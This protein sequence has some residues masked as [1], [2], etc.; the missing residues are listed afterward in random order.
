MSHLSSSEYC[1]LRR[2]LAGWAARFTPNH[3]LQAHLIE[4]TIAETLRTYPEKGEDAAIDVE[5]FDTMRRLALKEFK[6]GK[7]VHPHS[8]STRHSPVKPFMEESF[9]TTRA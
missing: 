1:L 2:L 3:S 9:D 7:N 5:L 6:V 8:P 4:T